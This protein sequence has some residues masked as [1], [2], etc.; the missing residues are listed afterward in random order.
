MRLFAVIVVLLT[1]PAFA[2]DSL[3][4]RGRIVFDPWVRVDDAPGLS[5]HPASHP[6]TYM[7]DNW[8]LYSV[9]ADDRDDNGQ[10]EVYFACSR[11]TGRT[12]SVPNVNLSQGPSQYYMFPWLAVDRTGLYVVWQSWRSNAWKV[13]FTRSTDE[14]VTWATPAEVPGITVVNG[15]NSGINF[16]PQPKLAVDSK[17]DPDSTFLYMVWADNATGAIQIKLARSVNLGVS[18]TDLGI[19]DKNPGNVNR[20]PFIAVDD[21]GW[22]HCAWARGTSGSNQDP[23][24]WIGYNRSTDRGASFMASDIIVNDDVTSVYRGNPSITY[25][26]LQRYV[27]I[28]W[29]D[30]R[31]AGGN[32]NPDV[33]FSRVRRDSLVFRPNQRVNW[34]QP[35]TGA[36]YD[37]YKPV[38]RMDPRGVM[39]AAWH[40][41]PESDN[42]YGIHLAAYTDS[43]GRFCNS[44]AIVAT[45]TGTSGGNFGNAFYPPSLFVRALI[46]G[47]DT[48]THFFVVWQ[49]FKEDLTGGNIYSVH[50]RV[51]TRPPWP[52]GWHEVKPPVPALPSSY[53]VKDGGW[54][55]MNENTGLINVAKGNKRDDFYSY[56]PLDSTPSAWRTLAAWPLGTEG[57]PPSK[58]SC[59][60]SDH[61]SYVYAAKGNSTVG[62]WRYDV[63]HDSW[64]QLADVSEGESGKRVKGG[65]DIVYA[66]ENG[67][68]YIY[69]LKGGCTDFLRY[70]IQGD[71]WS[72]MPSA[73]PGTKPKW[74][75]GS[76]LAY[77]GGGTIYAHKGKYNELWPFN[78]ATHAWGTQLASMP[79]ISRYSGKSK[80]SK[81]GSS[82]AAY[83]SHVYA[84]KGGNTCEFWRYDAVTDSW[85]EKD[86]M[87]QV[88]STLKKKRVKGGGD[89]VS[90]GDWWAFFAL[91]GNKTLELWRYVDSTP[92]RTYS[93]EP[94]RDQGAQ[95]SS[96]AAR[97]AMKIRPSIVTTGFATLSFGG[98]MP[99]VPVQVTVSDI[100]G[101]V[102]V[103]RSITTALPVWPLDVRSLAPG[104]YFVR[105]STP[106][107][108]QSAPVKFVVER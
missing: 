94:D 18:F 17:S 8:N 5:G 56:D 51:I 1:V 96:S 22:V 14:G 12:W 42:S 39:V 40:D 60:A 54:L 47:R 32:A 3:P 72:S 57:K 82:G 67:R 62:F 27:V 103:S 35:D 91:K 44:R 68:G 52:Y 74:D 4:W 83:G 15:L 98:R 23:H 30:S 84:L 99:F 37:C 107:I 100:S 49:D 78:L 71:S 46:D 75:K 108:A 43:L 7:D 28:S 63:V 13:Y 92:P 89:I 20:H 101:R 90:Y 45:L 70:S 50:G 77:D 10:F 34:W 76:W 104:V 21:S 69:L 106:D 41:D 85:Y 26:Q 11:D 61:G 73:P 58:G 105:S 59:G 95:A 53:P 16:G 38:V 80:K 19:V 93:P 97:T 31:R 102:V 48:T 79:L 9:W 86:T 55:A 24:C 88:G 64:K 36:R 29:E 87:P 81:D 65:T 25:D 6:Q 33:W 66:A 2:Q